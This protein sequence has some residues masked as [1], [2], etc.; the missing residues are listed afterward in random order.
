MKTDKALKLF[1]IPNIY[2]TKRAHVEIRKKIVRNLLGEIRNASILDIGCGD[3]SI[4][5]QFSSET[6][7]LTLVDFSN[8]MLEIARKNVS[9]EFETNVQIIHKNIDEYVS[10]LLFDIVLCIGVLA[11]VS[12]VEKT[13]EKTSRLLH[14]QG[15]YVV[16]ITDFDSLMGKFSYFYNST[17]IFFDHGYSLNKIGFS[18][19]LSITERHDLEFVK[20]TS[21]PSFFP[22]MGRLPDKWLYQYYFLGAHNPSFSR[23][24]SEVICLFKKRQ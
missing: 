8:S 15:Y 6:N 9:V 17:R 2:L 7:H 20:K 1:E 23:I 24:G 4:S 18:N 12:D 13:I 16:Q 19:L 11:H 21:Y 22:G 5:L 3:G 10:P 14:P